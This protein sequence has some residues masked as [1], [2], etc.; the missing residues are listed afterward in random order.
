MTGPVLPLLLL[1][2]ALLL[3]CSGLLVLVLTRRGGPGA[4]VGCVLMGGA[5]LA[6]A[7]LSLLPAIRGS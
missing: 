6:V 1:V 5:A 3:A 2:G 4:L 7:L